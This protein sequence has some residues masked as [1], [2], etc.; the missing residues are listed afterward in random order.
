[1]KIAKFDFAINLGFYGENS[2]TIKHL[3]NKGLK[4]S[5]WYLIDVYISWKD[6]VETA[7][8]FDDIW[9]SD[10]YSESLKEKFVS[11]SRNLNGLFW[12][13]KEW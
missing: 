12:Y 4:E 10:R 13:I 1:M 7:W 2:L 9:C 11:L 3:G 6:G 5:I 8:T